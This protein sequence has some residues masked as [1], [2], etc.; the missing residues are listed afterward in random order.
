M[1][2]TVKETKTETD[3]P[4]ESELI[5]QTYTQSKAPAAS[6]ATKELDDLMDSLS[7]IKVSIFYQSYYLTIDYIGNVIA[8]N[9]H[10]ENFAR[11][12]LLLGFA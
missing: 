2:I 3:F 11:D 9:R 10:L 1:T 6:T 4:S 12:L 5:Q 7:E 8:K